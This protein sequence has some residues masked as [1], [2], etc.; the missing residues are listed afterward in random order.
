MVIFLYFL[1]I[2]FYSSNILDIIQST[3]IYLLVFRAV[4]NAFTFFILSI[5]KKQYFS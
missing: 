4:N 2:I 1:C 3:N 5:N